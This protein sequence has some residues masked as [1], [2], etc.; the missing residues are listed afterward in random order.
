M[1]ISNESYL[2][3]SRP[4]PCSNEYVAVSEALWEALSQATSLRDLGLA[5]GAVEAPLWDE[6]ST[7][8]EGNSAAMAPIKHVTSLT[9]SA[10]R[11]RLD[12]QRFASGF[13]P[14]SVTALHLP[15]GVVPRLDEALAA[16]RR[17][18]VLGHL[19]VDLGGI[20]A[21]GAAFVIP[22]IPVFSRHCPD[23]RRG[24]MRCKS[25]PSRLSRIRDQSDISHDPY[26]H[27]AT[28]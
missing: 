18:A 5:L 7:A 6:A 17:F 14:A 27:Q 10:A 20:G 21:G 9:I 16:V 25:A 28:V 19:T 11:W 15:A 23:V 1:P 2:S 24:C 8:F 4:P 26:S 12:A 13:A 3:S 22:F